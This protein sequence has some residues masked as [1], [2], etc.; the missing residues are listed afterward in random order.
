MSAA[1]KRGGTG[2]ATRGQ[3]P[4]ETAGRRGDRL[5]PGGFD[6]PASRGSGSQSGPAAPGRGSAPSA[7]PTGGPGSPGLQPPA[8]EAPAPSTSSRRS[9]QSGGAPPPQAQLA[10]PRGD[11]ARERADRYTDGLKNVDLPASFFNIDQLVSQLS[12]ISNSAPFQSV[13]HPPKSSS[14]Q[15][16]RHCPS[17]LPR[18]LYFGF[19]ISLLLPSFS[20]TSSCIHS[21]RRSLI[22][23]TFPPRMTPLKHV[24]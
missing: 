13:T 5:Q 24:P 11:P 3:Q 19:F 1:R 9:S 2:R 4:A 7:P 21:D 12:S 16:A 8:S 10:A 17:H 23:C 20:V 22:Y 15:S 6:G 18:D 14:C